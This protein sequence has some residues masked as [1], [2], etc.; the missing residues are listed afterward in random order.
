MHDE[1][2]PDTV[3]TIALFSEECY[4]AVVG[5]EAIVRLRLSQLRLERRAG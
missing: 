4:E 3:R 1:A 2:Q 5:E